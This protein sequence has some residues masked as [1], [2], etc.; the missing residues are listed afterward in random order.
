MKKQPVVFERQGEPGVWSVEYIDDDGG[1]EQAV[2][3]GHNAE[4]RCRVFASAYYS[5]VIEKSVT[6]E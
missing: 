3:I 2:F 5:I 1:I 4:N 6:D